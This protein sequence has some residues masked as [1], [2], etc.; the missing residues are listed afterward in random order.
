MIRQS[1]TELMMTYHPSNDWK[2]V[3][4]LEICVWL[5][6]FCIQVQFM[7]ASN[8]S[9]LLALSPVLEQHFPLVII[10][11]IRVSINYNGE[12]FAKSGVQRA[13]SGERALNDKRDIIA[14]ILIFHRAKVQTDQMWN[15]ALREAGSRNNNISPLAGPGDIW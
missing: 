11:I 3:P 9:P 2:A 8:Y 12:L 15:E 10:K 7:F 1:L 4:N 5:S 13:M 6:L 14:I